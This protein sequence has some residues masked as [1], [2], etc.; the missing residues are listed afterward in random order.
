MV[1]V[2]NFGDLKFC[3]GDIAIRAFLRKTG[4]YLGSWINRDFSLTDS[5]DFTI[6]IQNIARI[7]NAVQCQNQLSGNNNCHEF[8]FSIVKL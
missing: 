6:D 3:F 8:K 2:F 5:Q 4:G 7:A 1:F